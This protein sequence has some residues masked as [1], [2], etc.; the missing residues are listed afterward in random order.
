MILRPAVFVLFVS[1]FQVCSAF[2]A[3]EPVVAVR[4][5]CLGLNQISADTNAAQFM[6]IWQL[7][8]TRALVA[9]TLDKL[10]RWPGHGATNETSARLRPLLDD[11]ISSEFYLEI[12]SLSA[13]R[14]PAGSVNPPS[15][16][17]HP[18]FLLALRLPAARARIWQTNLAAL[19]RPEK[20]T[21]SRHDDW[22]LVGLG[23]D[24]NLA[25]TEFAARI[26]HPQKTPS[27][28]SWLTA[29][30]DLSRL[31]AVFSSL[32]TGMGKSA[33]KLGE[34]DLLTSLNFQLSS[35]DHL[36]LTV[37]GDASNVLVHAMLDLSKSLPASLPSWE[38][39]TNLM[40][41]SLTS[42]AAVRGLADWVGGLPAWR[43][44]KLNPP[45]DQAFCWAEDGTPFLT[46]LAFPLPA[47]SN[48][49]AQ[50]SARI[51]P[52]VNPWLATHASGKILSPT[53]ESILVWWD[54]PYISPFAKAVQAGGHDYFQAGLSIVTGRNPP[55]L[56]DYLKTI[57][58]NPRLIY[59]QKE[60]TTGQ[61]IQDGMFMFQMLRLAF[62]K[63]QLPPTSAADTWLRILEPKLGDSTTIVSQSGPCQLVF[64]RTSSIGFT[65]LELHLLAD[66]LE[67]P[68][69]PHGLHTFLAPPDTN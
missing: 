69:F 61:R 66:W 27:T 17:R 5:H 23:L 31:A 64:D 59:Y 52:A 33:T 15:A 3:A 12:P 6:K 1:L 50:L 20:I 37:S 63:P 14:G 56:D 42:F 53:N 22:T 10:S 57:H 38:I 32:S 24:E 54:L 58:G 55:M 4:I 34:P 7:P 26:L 68:Q 43:R 21:F 48:Q 16:I 8:E 60:Q 41:G 39:P 45:P 62:N 46:Y 40:H 9:Q 49:L 28:N 35:S 11:L 30:L 67:S 51:V 36:H 29:D 44:F 13:T 19:T 65:A 2:A 47:A 18:Q 25:Q